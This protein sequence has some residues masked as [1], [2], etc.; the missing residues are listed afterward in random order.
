[1]K[2]YLF[3]IVLACCMFI[4]N[5][6]QAKTGSYTFFWEGT[7]DP[8]AE[9]QVTAKAQD[10]TTY[11]ETFVVGGQTAEQTRNTII[12]DLQ[13]AGWNVANNGSN[14]IIIT[15]H[16]TSPVEEIDIHD[17]RIMVVSKCDG[18]VNIVSTN[19]GNRTFSFFFDDPAAG[20]LAPGII[21]L[22]LNDIIVSAPLAPGDGPLPAAQKLH[23]ALS[24]AGYVVNLN[25]NTVSLDW[26]DPVNFNLIGDQVHIDL[27]NLDSESGPHLKLILPDTTEQQSI[28]TLSEWGLIILAALLLMTASFYLLKR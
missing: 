19:P 7:A 3:P 11:N 27:Y 20:L 1:M 12:T 5:T 13:S 6:V 23:L 16:G 2:K 15:G 18:N 26:D 14:G 10:G 9:I 21:T 8:A 25:G 4:M 28:P 17:T 22:E 24:S